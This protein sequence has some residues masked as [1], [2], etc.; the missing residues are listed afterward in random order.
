MSQTKNLMDEVPDYMARSEELAIKIGMK[1]D[2]IKEFKDRHTAGLTE[3]NVWCLFH[4]MPSYW[5]DDYL[6]RNFD[7]WNM[8]WSDIELLEISE[9]SKQ[10]IKSIENCDKCKKEILRDAPEEYFVGHAISTFLFKN[11]AELYREKRKINQDRCK[12]YLV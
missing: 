11:E 7:R 4:Q 5:L 12:H 10:K 6:L 1:S 3:D 8:E 9:I 2:A